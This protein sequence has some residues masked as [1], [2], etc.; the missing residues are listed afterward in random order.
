MKLFKLLTCASLLVFLTTGCSIDSKSPE[1]LIK[2]KPVYNENKEILY[3]GINQLLPLNSSL[4]LPSNSSEVGKINN[5]DLNGDGVEELVAFEKK[6]NLNDNQNKV[7]FIVLSK[8]EDE[9]YTNKGNLLQVG[10]YIEYANFYDLNNDG[11]KEIILLIKN[12]NK[13]NMHI[14]NFKEDE[15]KSIYTL[16]PTWI[17]NKQN[18]LDVK[19]KVG[20]IDDN[21]KLDILIM[22]YD[23]KNSKAYASLANFNKSLELID[24]TEFSNVKN[25]SDLYITIG[26]IAT[27]KVGNTK[28]EKKGVILDIPIIQDNNYITQILYIKDQKI[29]KAF[30]DDDKST[31]K[32]YYIPIEDIN[33]D[34]VIEIPIV[35]G[36]GNIYTQKNSANIS[37]YKW[38]GKE[39]DEKSSL[40]FIIQIYYNYQYNYKMLI[41][42]KLVNK[43]DIVQEY[44]GNDVLFKFYYYDTVDVKLKNLF[45]ISLVNKNLIDDKK[46]ASSSNGIILNETN[47]YSF[48]LYQNDLEE[49]KKL[50]INIEAL[51]EY[52]SLIY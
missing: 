5:V 29:K 33:K 19:I 39:D 41:P 2:Y 25:L 22:H 35:N 20:Y 32:P 36:S 43:V 34:K 21:D 6:E 48:I 44:K 42:N 45:T 24:F 9:T 52:F 38:N 50:N 4:I 26:T 7:G 18:L 16:N 12:R 30:S 49:L 40:V 23:P 13:T 14:Y 28:I 10:D 51:R 8:N 37:W 11:Y 27:E 46:N 3:K 17:K 15:I 1:E 31:M 47:E